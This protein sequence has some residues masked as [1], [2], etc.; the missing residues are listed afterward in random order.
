MV[1]D[2]VKGASYTGYNKFILLNCHG[3]EWVL[4]MA[5]QQLGSEGYFVIAVTLWDIAKSA[6]LE[7]METPFFHAEETETSLGLF[8]VPELVDM[9]KARDEM[10]KPLIDRKWIAG[11]GG[12]VK[13]TIPWFNAT[14]AQPEYKELKYGV[15]GYPT[16]ASRAKGKKVLDA[17]VDYLSKLI[18]EI[19]AKYPPGVKPPIK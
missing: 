2:I 12:L 17:A 16:K 13:D 14:Y 8:L 3:Q 1:I 19:K 5:V 9:S 7:T 10:T 6:I 18:E 4:P 15:I 11:P